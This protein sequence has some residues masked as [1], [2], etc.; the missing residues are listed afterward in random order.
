MF[1][2]IFFSL[3]DNLHE[4]ISSP[5]SGS[6]IIS[7]L[8]WQWQPIY[9]LLAQD[10]TMSINQ[11]IDKVLAISNINSL[12]FFPLISTV[13]IISVVPLASAL[14]LW[15]KNKY[16]K[17]YLLINKNKPL[18]PDEAAK[19]REVIAKREGEINNLISNREE[20]Y[21]KVR[22]ENQKQKIQIQELENNRVNLKDYKL[23]NG[24]LQDKIDALK[25]D[26]AQRPPKMKF[27]MEDVESVYKELSET[28]KFGRDLLGM[29][30][31]LDNEPNN[32]FVCNTFF[33]LSSE[34]RSK[35]IGDNIVAIIDIEG[36]E[37]EEDERKAFLTEFGKSLLIVNL[38]RY[39]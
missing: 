21:E 5:L 2:D 36:E 13:L 39:N 1:K 24:R 26:L 17:L 30:K 25:L 20:K 35:F 10:Y 22:T 9:I 14:A 31:N 29:F 23:I 34:S 18:S 16:Y 28:Q 38:K 19:H 15:V 8:A 6:F 27:S 4:R 37:D 33:D 11:R 3:R 7:W 32:Q 12:M